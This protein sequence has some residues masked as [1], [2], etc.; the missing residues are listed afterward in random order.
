MTSVI[1]TPSR[2]PLPLHTGMSR[3]EWE[4][5]GKG[6]RDAAEW[7]Q[8]AIGE[9][10]NF[11]RRE[12][13]EAIT[14]E[15]AAAITGYAVPTLHNLASVSLRISPRGEMSWAHHREVAALEPAEQ[16]RWLD[17]AEKEDWSTRELRDQLRLTRPTVE[18]TN[19]ATLAIPKCRRCGNQCRACEIEILAAKK[20]TKGRK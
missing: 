9:W 7:T 5:A 14:Y 13:G 11:G 6:L 19:T 3:E 16:D 1:S 18:P 8:W 10:L 17:K 12:F 15:R 2:T 20:K 4:A